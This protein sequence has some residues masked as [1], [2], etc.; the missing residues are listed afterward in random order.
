MNIAV[1]EDALN[2]KIDQ[3]EI[4]MYRSIWRSTS[5]TI[6]SF[7]FLTLLSH[8]FWPILGPKLKS[9]LKD[10]KAAGLWW[11][12]AKT[13]FEVRTRRGML[14][15]GNSP[16]LRRIEQGTCEHIACH[17]FTFQ[18]VGLQRNAVPTFNFP[19]KGKLYVFR[20]VYIY[21]QHL[22]NWTN[23][24]IIDW[25]IGTKNCWTGERPVPDDFGLF[26]NEIRTSSQ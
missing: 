8:K 15:G 14:C 3:I 6:S 10:Q 25:D 11:T 26:L 23:Y 19:L 2:I 1:P 20:I 13:S 18:S 16:Q 21:P 22:H 24:C 17:R 9:F 12:V 7:L 4:D 5:L